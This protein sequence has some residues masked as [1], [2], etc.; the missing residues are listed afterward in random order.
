MIQYIRLEH[1]RPSWKD[2][3][4]FIKETYIS[5]QWEYRRNFSMVD[6]GTSTVN[7]IMTKLSDI[8]VNSV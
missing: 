4:E 1:L 8:Y 2:H 6:Q 7:N 3:S 5:H